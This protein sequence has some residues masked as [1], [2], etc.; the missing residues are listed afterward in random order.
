MNSSAAS[1]KPTP[2][3][4]YRWMILPLLL[5]LATVAL[6]SRTDEQEK[7]IDV[8]VTF[9]NIA[10]DLLLMDGPRHS[11]KLLV[12]GTAPALRT[13]DSKTAVVRLDLS[14]LEAGTHTIP[15]DA[16]QVTLPDKVSL[17]A[18]LTPWLTARLEM[19]TVKTVDAVAVLEG[20]L[21][22]GFAVVGVD[23]RPDR[24]VLK[25][26]ATILA[27][28]ETVK[29]YPINLESASETFKK[30]VPLNL[31]EVVDVEPPLRI[32]L[33]EV[34]VKERIVTR[35]LEG[36]PVTA[37]G[38]SAPHQIR[39][40]TITLSVSGPQ[41]IV[42]DIESDPAFA[43]SIDLSGLRAGDHLL[44][45]TINLPIQTT[46]VQVSPEHFAVTIEK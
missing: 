33:A 11:V 4:R 28:I 44:K 22:P 6:I 14:G 36:I 3:T 31:P 35:V 41:T 16:S 15:I 46:L 24:I 34:A 37:S 20:H 19:L 29:T 10:V 23:L 9:E 13:I 26:P 12:A 8:A 21:A 18:V 43:V 38:S 30:E 5:G 27:D 2:G 45:A 32:V 42:A 40:E 7:E 25:G 1:H 17:K 39:P